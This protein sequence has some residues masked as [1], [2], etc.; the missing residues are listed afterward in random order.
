MA[1]ATWLKVYLAAVLGFVVFSNSSLKAEDKQLIDLSK[2]DSK[3]LQVE[4]VKARII[5][6]DK[7]KVESGSNVE[8]PSITLTSPD[9]KWDLSEYE[10][11]EVDVKNLLDKEMRV[12]FRV[13]DPTSNEPNDREHEHPLCLS[14]NSSG[15]A[16]IRLYPTRWVFSSN[17]IE[18]KGMRRY[19]GEPSKVDTKNVTKIIFY[20][21]RPQFDTAYEI[22]NIRVGGQVEKISSDNFLPFIDE[23]GQFMHYDWPGKTRSIEEMKN[24]IKKEEQQLTAYPGPKDRNKYGGFKTGP[25]LKA[26]GFF[27]VEKYQGKWWFVDPE[28]HL[29]WSHGIDCVWPGTETGVSDRREYFKDL[30]ERRSLLGKFYDRGKGHIYGFYKKRRF[31]YRSHCLP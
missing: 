30:P 20:D 14:P 2:Y 24:Q 4:D 26:T 10:Y 12:F 3:L 11:I 7:I 6:G 8:H 19:P 9:G 31:R 29:F 5:D 17:P 21:F 15:T 1:K 18:L 13:E 28:G 23:F 16:T 27:R 22:S 25:Q